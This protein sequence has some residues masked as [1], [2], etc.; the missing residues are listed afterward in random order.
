MT[1]NISDNMKD[2]LLQHIDNLTPVNMGSH[3]TS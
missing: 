2:F 1:D 3:H